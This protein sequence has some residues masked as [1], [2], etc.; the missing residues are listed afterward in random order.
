MQGT[1]NLNLSGL[2]CSVVR[3]G[4]GR[5]ERDRSSADVF[6]LMLYGT[7]GQKF[8][9]NFVWN[10]VMVFWNNQKLVVVTHAKQ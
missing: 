3:A 9:R 1:S 8:I 7:S 6:G 2:E 10:L 4:V 5:E